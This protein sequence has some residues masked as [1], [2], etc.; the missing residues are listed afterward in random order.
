MSFCSSSSLV[1]PKSPS[2]CSD[3]FIQP[4]SCLFDISSN[5]WFPDSSNTQIYLF[6]AQY[7]FISLSHIIA[8]TDTA[9]TNVEIYGD[10]LLF[11]DCVTARAPEAVRS[12]ADCQRPYSDIPVICC[13]ICIIIGIILKSLS[14]PLSSLRRESACSSPS[15]HITPQGLPDSSSCSFISRFFGAMNVGFASFR[16]QSNLALVNEFATSSNCLIRYGIP[17]QNR[18]SV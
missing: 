4:R 15:V 10:I 6:S 8:T 11:D 1:L 13:A 12:H 3:I 7:F 18:A 14:P 2:G 16:A 5:I 9:S 17:S